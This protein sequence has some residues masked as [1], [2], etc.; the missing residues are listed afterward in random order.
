MTKEWKNPK[1]K[2]LSFQKDL[3][4]L[5]EEYDYVM[6][7]RLIINAH[8][9]KPQI[10]VDTPQN[11]VKRPTP[12]QI[13]KVIQAKQSNKGDVKQENQEQKPVGKSE[14]DEGKDKSS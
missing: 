7:C 10:V 13:A 12:D 11:M 5:L 6:D 8:G 2:L 4:I 3:Q 1:V 9:I 14:T